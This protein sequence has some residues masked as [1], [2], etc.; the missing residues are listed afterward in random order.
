LVNIGNELQE[1]VDKYRI[2]NDEYRESL[3]KRIKGYE[4]NIFTH[5]IGKNLSTH[6]RFTLWMKKVGGPPSNGVETLR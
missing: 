1:V 2:A 6:S 3:T 5:E 4:F